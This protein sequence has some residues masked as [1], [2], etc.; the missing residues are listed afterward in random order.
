MD[1]RT[2]IVIATRNRA[3]TLR[4]TLEHLQ[5]LPEAPPIVVVDNGSAPGTLAPLRESFPAVRFLELG[6]NFGGAARNA[7]ARVLDRPYVAFSDDDSW[8][9]PGS[10]AR[11]GDWLD[12]HPRLAL[13]AARV[14]V[15]PGHQ[16]DPCC[17]Q[18]AAS[19]IPRPDWLP[20]PAVLGFLA[21]GAVVR[22]SALLE[23]G[24]FE[25]RF[26]IGGEE[27]LLAIDLAINGWYLAYGA[28]I[29]A[30]H[31][32]SATGDR[33]GR[34]RTQYRN[35]LWSAWLRRRWPGALRRTG[36]I[37]ALGLSDGD[38]R[39]A[40]R[41]ALHGLP[42]IVRARRPAPLGIETS[43]RGIDRGY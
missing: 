4:V 35:A 14:L 27:E 21:C 12:A 40:L 29:V 17:E 22:R 8:W 30:H 7:G 13:V 41:D 24:G 34:R 25:R 36:R 23:V 2:G 15:G 38:A 42:W 37:M 10:L 32:P 28:D 26:G 31:H 43:L 3:A 20:G 6:D 1:P 19:P 16:P 33:G 39:A 9:S 18:M 11:A 5:T